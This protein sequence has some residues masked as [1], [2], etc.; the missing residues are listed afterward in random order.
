MDAKH[1][2]EGGR[3]LRRDQEKTLLEVEEVVIPA[4][5]LGGGDLDSDQREGRTGRISPGNIGLVDISTRMAP[6]YLRGF[7]AGKDIGLGSIELDY[8]LVPESYRFSTTGSSNHLLSAVSHSGDLTGKIDME[9]IDGG[10]IHLPITILGRLIAERYLGNGTTYRQTVA[11]NTIKDGFESP[12]ITTKFIKRGEE[13]DTRSVL[14]ATIFETPA[15]GK[16]GVFR[17]EFSGPESKYEP[18]KEEMIRLFWKL[19]HSI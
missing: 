6:G 19:H 5:A 3:G 17:T 7:L 16:F 14:I 10:T 12:T 15:P 2:Q 11:T 13:E 8:S 9:L 4:G 1:Q 18:R